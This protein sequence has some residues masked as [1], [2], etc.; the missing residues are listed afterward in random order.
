MGILIPINALKTHFVGLEQRRA[1][2]RTHRRLCFAEFRQR[3]TGNRR[4]R[5]SWSRLRYIAKARL[6]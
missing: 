4:F 3:G 2:I 5:A 1:G 6:L